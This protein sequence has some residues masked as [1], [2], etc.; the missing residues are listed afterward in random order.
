MLTPGD[1][2]SDHSF[3]IAGFIPFY[4]FPRADEPDG[5]TIFMM[6]ALFSAEGDFAIAWSKT[7]YTA[8]GKGKKRT[9]I[10]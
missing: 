7:L 1:I 9:L 6:I 3:G 8:R 5:R 2:D 10:I 4:Y